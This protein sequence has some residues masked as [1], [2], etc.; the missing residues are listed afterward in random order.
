VAISFYRCLI[1]PIQDQAHLAFENWGQSD[2]T[3]VV[4]HKVPKT[5]M[6]TR[7]KSIFGGRIRN[8]ECPKVLGMYHPSDPVCLRLRFVSKIGLQ[9]SLL[10][11]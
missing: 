10:Q 2:P 3:R 6:T 1:Q 4:K 9:I 8:R 7:V 11:T 5:E